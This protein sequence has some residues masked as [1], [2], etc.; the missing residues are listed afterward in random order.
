MLTWCSEEEEVV[1]SIN[2]YAT[3]KADGNDTPELDK[4][5]FK[6]IREFESLSVADREG[7]LS[8]H[9]SPVCKARNDF[10]LVY[11]NTPKRLKRKPIL[12]PILYTCHTKKTPWGFRIPIV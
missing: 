10:T 4:A 7:A 12:F 9:L 3:A 2:D 8:N 6:F 1:K 11:N 5:Y